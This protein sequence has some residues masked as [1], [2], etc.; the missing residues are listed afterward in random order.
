MVLYWWLLILLIIGYCEEVE[1]ALT[2]TI[3]SRFTKTDQQVVE[4]ASR[5]K[6]HRCF[7]E[8]EAYAA[9]FLVTK[10]HFLSK[11]SIDLNSTHMSME[12]ASFMFMETRKQSKFKEKIGAIIQTLDVLDLSVVH[13]SAYERSLRHEGRINR[14]DS[15]RD[16]IMEP[17]I[18]RIY[19]I[20]NAI[21]SAVTKHPQSTISQHE[22]YAKTLVLLPWAGSELGVGN[23]RLT[24]RQEYLRICFWSF[25]RYYS[26]D[27][28]IIGVHSQNDANIIKDILKLPA[29][30]IWIL[31]NASIDRLP[32]ALIKEAQK[33]FQSNHDSLWHAFNYIF[34]SESDQL[35]VSRPEEYVNKTHAQPLELYDMLDTYPRAVLSPHR[36]IPYAHELLKNKYGIIPKN[37]YTTY[38]QLDSDDMNVNHMMCCLKRQ[39][40]D[41]R[42][43][44]NQKTWIPLS[45]PNLPFIEIDG[46]MVA[47]G[48]ANFRKGVFRPCKLLPY[49]NICPFN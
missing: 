22:K 12:S 28:I 18:K 6:F 34:F 21:E 29:R 2:G 37:K 19:T 3:K 33:R 39:N 11:Q 16:S 27:N 25:Y 35:H 23:S 9:S 7:D 38:G 26:N 5:L 46:F 14:Y 48:N 44:M 32:H 40:C 41:E 45:S 17:A 31:S 47:M 13:L 49:K 20:A 15:I 43:R 4:D 8:G 36:L 1:A 42:D 30:E 10:H 24:Y